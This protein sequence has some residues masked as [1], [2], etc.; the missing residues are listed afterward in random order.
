MP[1]HVF[2]S[3][4]CA[5]VREQIHQDRERE[6]ESLVTAFSLAL[7]VPRSLASLNRNLFPAELIRRI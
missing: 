1:I 6:R 7:I 5:H 2:S 4:P 3:L